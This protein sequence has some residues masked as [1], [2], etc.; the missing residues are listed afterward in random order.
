[1]LSVWLVYAYWEHNFSQFCQSVSW[2]G[3]YRFPIHHIAVTM[4]KLRH[5]MVL[6]V[7][8]SAQLCADTAPAP[9][10]GGTL[11]VNSFNGEWESWLESALDLPP[12]FR[13]QRLRRSCISKFCLICIIPIAVHLMDLETENWYLFID[14]KISP[15]SQLR[16][17]SP[18]A[19]IPISISKKLLGVT[20]ELTQGQWWTHNSERSSREQ[21]PAA[22]R[23]ARYN[24]NL[25]NFKCRRNIRKV[26]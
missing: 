18:F 20:G 15:G 5:S 2:F 24:E 12:E 7:L 14:W 10:I 17:L 8:Y 9:T 6:A 22:S 3:K 19:R 16:P 11:S 21:R 26:L 13:V 1:M 4:S 23:L 25:G